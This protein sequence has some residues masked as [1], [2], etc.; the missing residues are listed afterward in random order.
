[1]PYEKKVSSVTGRHWGSQ[2]KICFGIKMSTS[3]GEFTSEEFSSYMKLKTKAVEKKRKEKMW[4]WQP[5]T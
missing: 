1:M 4:S 3:V 2:R 5:P